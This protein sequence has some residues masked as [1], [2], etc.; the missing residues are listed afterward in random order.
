MNKKKERESIGKKIHQLA[1]KLWPI[2]RSITGNGVR[3]SLKI[4][5]GIYPKLLIV[6]VQSGK[7]V[8]DWTI[9]QEWNVR[10]A[11]IKGSKNK[12]IIDF[13]DNN[14]H[15]VGYSRPIKTTLNLKELKK[16]LYSL[17]NQPNAIP[18]VTSYYKKRWG[19]CIS[20]KKKKKL[21]SGNYKVFIDSKFKKGSLTYGEIIIPGSSKK[22]I[23]LSTNICHPSMA[24]NELSG[25]TVTI[26]LA[27]WI[28]SLKLPS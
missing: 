14:L 28:Q 18:Y 22:E 19:F 7:K 4:L 1:K 26:Y 6:E 13:A 20:E 8:F 15:L 24:N 17:P 16:Y 10:E 27:K 23:F 2:N 5:K 21:Q 11:W 9:P 25:P 3:K 12:K